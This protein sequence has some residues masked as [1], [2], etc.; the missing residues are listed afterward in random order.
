MKAAAAR[1]NSGGESYPATAAVVVD[2]SFKLSQ[3]TKKVLESL[4]VLGA[5]LLVGKIAR[6]F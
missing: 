5:V 4:L 2:S 3:P 1:V 6:G